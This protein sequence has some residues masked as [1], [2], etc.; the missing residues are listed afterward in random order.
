MR[1]YP[2]TGPMLKGEWLGTDAK[3]DDPLSLLKLRRTGRHHCEEQKS[4]IK[5]ESRKAGNDSPKST[6]PMKLDE[7]SRRDG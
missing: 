7:R 2:F 1:D 4:R 5:K 3:G 6:K